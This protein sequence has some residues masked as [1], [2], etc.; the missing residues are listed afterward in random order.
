MAFEV[1][2]DCH[3]YHMAHSAAIHKLLF[4]LSDLL[5]FDI[6]IFINIKRLA[7]PDGAVNLWNKTTRTGYGTGYGTG[8]RW[9]T[10]GGTPCLFSV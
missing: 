8:Y 10:G 5:E 7:L 4:F 1:V 6:L 2:I 9:G 3:S